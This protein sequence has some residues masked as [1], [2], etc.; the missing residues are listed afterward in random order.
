[1]GIFPPT[2]VKILTKLA[3]HDFKRDITCLPPS[4][5]FDRSQPSSYPPHPGRLSS[6]P[7]R[8]E[9]L[10][11]RRLSQPVGSSYR[12]QPLPTRWPLHRMGTV[13][14]RGRKK[15][16]VCGTD[17]IIKTHF[18]WK[19]KRFRSVFDV[20][21]RRCLFTFD[22][23]FHDVE[24]FPVN[25]ILQPAIKARRNHFKWSIILNFSFEQSDLEWKAYFLFIYFLMG[26]VGRRYFRGFIKCQ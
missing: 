13:G 26:G 9:I 17:F 11:P 24:E 25:F 5:V 23:S 15:K 7:W 1:M 16:G 14:G 20:V 12:G 22:K 19:F 6:S 3:L 21:E 8:G 2:E 10:H 4:S 18:Q